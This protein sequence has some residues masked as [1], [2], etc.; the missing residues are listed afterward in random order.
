MRTLLMLT[1]LLSGCTS[2]HVEQN[3]RNGTTS[4]GE[5][6]AHGNIILKKECNIKVEPESAK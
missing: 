6:G 2:Y 1:L 4:C 3:S 5:K